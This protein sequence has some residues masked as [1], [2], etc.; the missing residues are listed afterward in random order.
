MWFILS[1]ITTHQALCL[2][3]QDI[4]WST[5]IGIEVKTEESHAFISINLLQ[6][7]RRFVFFSYLKLSTSCILQTLHFITWIPT[8]YP[9]I[10]PYSLSFIIAR[11][12][13]NYNLGHPCKASAN[14]LLTFT[15]GC[16]WITYQGLTHRCTTIMILW[17]HKTR[18]DVTGI[19][20]TNWDVSL[21]LD[22]I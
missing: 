3:G 12:C 21:H 10:Y 15:F 5:L 2:I 17:F 1:S 20:Q 7:L 13:F 9:I 22:Q 4:K 11:N 18:S 14:S 8:W 16:I 19:V 6:L